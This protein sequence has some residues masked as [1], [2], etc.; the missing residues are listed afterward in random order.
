MKPASIISLVIAVLLVIVGLVGCIIGQNMAKAN[1]EYL[2]AEDRDGD[3]IQTVD[4]NESDISKIQLIFSNAEVNI[5][6]RQEKSYIEFINFR[7]NYYT[8]ST[9]NRVL[10]FDEIP[11]LKSMLKFWENGFSF[12]GMRYILSF[13]EQADESRQKVINIYLTNDKDIKIFD[14]K[15]QS[16]TLNISE[17]TTG[18]DYNIYSDNAVINGN[19][20]RTSSFVNILG[21]DGKSASKSVALELDTALIKNF[22]VKADVLNMNANKFRCSG[23]GVFSCTSGSIALLTV[24]DPTSVK[25]DI[26]SSGDISINGSSV[27]SPYIQNGSG[28]SQADLKFDVGSASVSIAAVSSSQ[29]AEETNNN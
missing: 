24:S 6:G 29:N 19:V 13:R 10:S 1:G 2:F 28:N 14:I 21:Y 4:L 25:L 5:I 11:D 9:T 22:S 27:T 8:V 16:L 26:T 20:L 18:T 7:E 23:D 17:M 3:M 12:K 15:G